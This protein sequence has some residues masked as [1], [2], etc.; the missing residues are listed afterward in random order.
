[1]LLD[2][3]GKSWIYLKRTY[4]HNYLHTFHLNQNFHQVATIYNYYKLTFQDY[5]V[6][7]L[8]VYLKE[9]FL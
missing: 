2:T 7:F 8:N 9:K 4:S 3:N 1:M 6:E 5:H